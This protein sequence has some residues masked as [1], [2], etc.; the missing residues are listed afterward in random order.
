MCAPHEISPPGF[1]AECHLVSVSA[2]A[3]AASLVGV[4]RSQ[5][6]TANHFIHVD[7]SVTLHTRQTRL[8]EILSLFSE[9]K[10]CIFVRQYIFVTVFF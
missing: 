2:A 8:T 5:C 9:L 3:A 10:Y 6:Q 4:D 7:C 1:G